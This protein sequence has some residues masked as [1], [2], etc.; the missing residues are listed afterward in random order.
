M[1]VGIRLLESNQ[2]IAQKILK[3][4]ALDYNKAM[5]KAV[6]RIKSR[7]QTETKPFFI[8]TDFYSS[9]SGGDLE[10]HFG[11][12]RD[13]N[14]RI[15]TIIDSIIN[16]LFI[17]NIPAVVSGHGFSG[18]LQIAILRKDLDEVFSLSPR[19]LNVYNYSRRYPEGQ[20]L[21]WAEW[22]LKQGDTIIITGF[23]IDWGQTRGSRSGQA[24]MIEE[25]AGI[26]RVPP[27]HAGNL[28][29]ND[30]SR[31]LLNSKIAYGNMLK[32][33]IQEEI[34]RAM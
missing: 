9:L 18:E 21:P 25:N 6:P 33:I 30:L 24:L 14:Y 16:R 13:G 27:L 7:I 23:R 34:E 8:N 10:G 32:K 20:V 28:N 15:E 22:W 31:A 3:A 17:K 29:S 4:L 26:W 19:I 5:N 2:V 1:F 12:P 11:F